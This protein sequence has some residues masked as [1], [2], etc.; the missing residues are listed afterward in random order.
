MKTIKFVR[1]ANMWCVSWK[2]I[3]QKSKKEHQHIQWFSTE[4][5]ARKFLSQ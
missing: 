1:R 2:E 5:E 4:E 3:D